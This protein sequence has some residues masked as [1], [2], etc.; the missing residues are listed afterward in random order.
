MFNNMKKQAFKKLCGYLQ[1]I[2]TALLFFSVSFE[3]I[4]MLLLTALP[5]LPPVPE[6]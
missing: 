2:T 6:T 5:I 3:Q 4:Y 1:T